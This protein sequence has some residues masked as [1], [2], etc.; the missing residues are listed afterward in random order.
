MERVEDGQVVV[1]AHTKQLA[2]IINEMDAGLASEIGQPR[3]VSAVS[4]DSTPAAL[5]TRH[6][7]DHLEAADLVVIDISDKRA[8][9]MYEAGIVHALGLPY[10]FVT[11]Q[12]VKAVPYYFQENLVIPEFVFADGYD[13]N[14]TSHQQLRER[15]RLAVSQSGELA[16]F[17]QNRISEYYGY[18]IVDLSAPTGLATGYYINSVLRF[19]RQMSGFL[20]RDHVW[21][22]KESFEQPS[23]SA[24]GESA[25]I[26]QKVR[27]Q[28]DKANLR[29]LVVVIPPPELEN[30]FEND[31]AA[32]KGIVGNDGW[33]FERVS[34]LESADG[35]NRFGFGGIV[36]AEDRGI[37]IDVPR[38]VYALRHSP[39]V[40]RLYG[41]A[42]SG[43]FS[44][45]WGDDADPV[46]AMMRQMVG[47]F[48][49]TLRKFLLSIDTGERNRVHITDF[50]WINQAL[51][52]IGQ[53]GG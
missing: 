49:A 17:A 36:L 27:Q 47:S 3:A 13:P 52:R 11:K 31:L 12:T 6:V 4:P 37:V 38:T 26:D 18:P 9:V 22:A 39:R 44:V 23:V 32:L 7:M 15:L 24:S 50:A 46:G 8:N 33:S 43:G 21:L 40:Q 20:A 14:Q 53:R 10:V 5:I 30:S 34:I 28:L 25:V 51:S 2:R 42:M 19:T 45:A 16:R 29:H 35:A 48:T 1:E 41:P